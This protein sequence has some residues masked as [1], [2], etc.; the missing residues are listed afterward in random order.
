MEEFGLGWALA[1]IGLT[2]VVTTFGTWIVTR[3]SVSQE[4]QA[5]QEELDRHGTY[6][7]V[8]VSSI[9]DPFVMAAV[10]VVNDRGYP[11]QD[12][13][14]GPDSVEPSLDLPNDVDWKS[15]DPHLMDRI[16]TLPNEI[17]RAEKSLSHVAEYVSGP[18]DHDEWFSERRYQWGRIG[19][20]A[21]DLARDLR[22]RYKLR[23]P[24]F[25]QYDP[26]DVLEA[27]FRKQD[28]MRAMGAANAKRLVAKLKA[29]KTQG[30]A[31]GPSA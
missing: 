15:I 24:D 14:L 10:E 19:I 23:Q 16:L 27:A 31:S 28:E 29:K 5:R 3:Y 30:A 4:R 22:N 18:P 17:Q 20:L 21:L 8:R 6:L 7:A 13:E 12:G 9:L 1:G 26:R 2:A 25:S 11:D